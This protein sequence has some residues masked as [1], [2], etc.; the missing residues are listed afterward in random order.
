MGETAPSEGPAARWWPWGGAALAGALLWV[1]LREEAGAFSPDSFA[2]YLLG[3]RFWSTL[4]YANP[5]VRDFNIPISWPQVSR[6]FP[7]I[8][9]LLVGLSSRLFGLGVS[10]SL[11]PAAAVLIA[12][13]VS[14]RALALRLAGPGWPF[15][16]AAFPA[17]ALIDAGY[18]D[19]LAAGRSIPLAILLLLLALVTLLPTLEREEGLARRSGL[20]GGLLGAMLLVRSDDL[21]FVPA[22]LGAAL[23]AWGRVHGWRAAWRA[24]VVAGLALLAVMSPWMI[25]NLL[26][27][28]KPLVSHDAETAVTTFP[29]AA[30][31]LWFAP[32]RVV[33]TVF[34]EPGVWGQERLAWLAANLERSLG[35]THG[36]IVA[37]PVLLAATWRWLPGPVRA[38]GVV[39]V[40]HAVTRIALV[41]LTPY[42]DVRYLSALHLELVVLVAAGLGALISGRA[43]SRRLGVGAVV[44]VLLACSWKAVVAVRATG[45]VLWP[46]APREA[47]L[48]ERYRRIG[49]ALDALLPREALVASEDAEA[50]TYYTGRPS[51]YLPLNAMYLPQVD[52]R[53][54][55]EAWLR[56]LQPRALVAAPGFVRYWRMEAKVRAIPTP[57]DA[58]VLP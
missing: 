43:W 50:L 57:T 14:A 25:R 2:F 28:G 46:L 55:M 40:L 53:P 15:P 35:V 17:F 8:W 38:L 3:D 6:S 22:L 10:S 24:A 42:P 39:T 45:S 4:Q 33:P 47:V 51:V 56:A 36:L 1:G 44:V 32:G 30:Y 21:L 54:D 26:A 41:S 49:T 7:P 11:I 29:G 58:I 13:G 9:P 5:S 20:A 37:G 18:R 23:L 19:E 12:T 27:F 31:M 34:T 48:A 52:W 16:W